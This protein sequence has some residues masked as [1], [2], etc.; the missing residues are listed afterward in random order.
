MQNKMVVNV[1]VRYQR[2]LKFVVVY[3][4][5]FDIGMQL[6]VSEYEDTR[7]VALE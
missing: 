1:L 6:T 3:H 4:D 5:I 2:A 7:G